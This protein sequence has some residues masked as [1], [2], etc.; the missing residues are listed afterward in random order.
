MKKLLFALVVLALCSSVAMASVPDPGNSSVTPDYNNGVILVPYPGA[1]AVPYG[2]SVLTVTVKNSANNPIAGALVEVTFHADIA[3]CTSF[4]PTA[5]TNASGM[6][7]II[8]AGAGCVHNTANAAVVRANGII[9]RS[10]LNAKSPANSSAAGNSP[11]SSVNLSSLGA[12]VDAYN[13]FADGP[14]TQLIN[15]G[16]TGIGDM[17][18]VLDG[19]IEAY[20]CTLQ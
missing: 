6:A 4:V 10:F 5:T 9:I 18:I 3:L 2:A 14:C 7:E 11:E 19:Y 1:P 17:S 16:S 8:L 12:F 20:S 15:A 13:G